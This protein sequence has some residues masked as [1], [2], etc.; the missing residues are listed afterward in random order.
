MLTEAAEAALATGVP[1]EALDFAKTA[2]AL[3]PTSEAAHRSLMRAHADLG[4]IGGALRVFESYRA[5]LAEELGAD[6]S[7]QTLELHVQLL[8]ASGR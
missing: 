3:D 5:H 7:P 4:E 1:R 2:V 6:P 8:R